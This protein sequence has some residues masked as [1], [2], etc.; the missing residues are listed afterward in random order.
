MNTGNGPKRAIHSLHELPHDVEPG[1]DLWPG[2][3]ARLGE[4]PS[5]RE[6]RALVGSHGGIFRAWLPVA[7]AASLAL[8]AV[9]VWIGTGMDRQA[10]LPVA[11][12]AK[13]AVIRASLMDAD[14]Q[15]R[16][17][18]LL[19]ALPAKLA[20]LP[21]E[22]Q[23]RVKESLLSIQQAMQTI[24]SELGRDSGNALLQQLLI[25]TCQEEIRVLTAIRDAD[26]P[27]ARI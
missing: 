12:S 15:S 24:E 3:K 7:V 9:G 4:M 2:I 23:Q 10:A 18:D 5:R 16:R 19:Q 25:S 20:Q 22:S 1:S 8:V 6:E 13:G 17:A 14:Y 26:D 11:A 27:E 21:P